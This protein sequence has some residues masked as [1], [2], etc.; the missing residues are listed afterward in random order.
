ME[1]KSILR[2]PGGKQ[3]AVKI[4]ADYVPS[5]ESEICSPFL[6]GGAFE[7]Y[8]ASALNMKIHAYDNFLPLVEFWQTLFFRR[9]QLANR[10]ADFLPTLARDSFYQLQKTQGELGDKLARAAAFFV[11]NRASFSGCTLSGGMSPGHPRFTPSAVERLRCFPSASIKRNFSAQKM[12]FAD[13]IARHPNALIYAD[14]PYILRNQNLYGSR[15]D[16]HR[17]F[18]HAKLRDILISR[19]GKWL[20]SYN[21]CE[22][23]RRLYQGRVILNPQWRYGMSKNKNSRE[24]L[25][26]SAELSDTLSAQRGAA[27]VG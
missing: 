22:L 5:G 10:V 2:Y 26:L 3:R 7:L 15:G 25:I 17:G 11:I 27:V 24:L 4:L 12:D 16:G 8:C 23:V 19:G 13:S 1:V 20:L 14:P 21:D 18:D 6:G 9:M